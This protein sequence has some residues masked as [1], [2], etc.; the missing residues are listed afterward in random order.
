MRTILLLIFG[1]IIL[2]SCNNEDDVQNTVY[3]NE[4]GRRFIIFQDSLGNSIVKDSGTIRVS[5]NNNLYKF[6]FELM[7]QTKIDP[8]ENIQME[9]T[10]SNSLRN[11]NWTPT[12][13]ILL[14]RDSINISY[15]DGK[16]YWLVNAIK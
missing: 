6:D 13:F 8:I 15:Q 1:L 12:K 14:S 4:Y 10:G 7:N 3:K 11:I 5:K 2:F 9:M 16:R